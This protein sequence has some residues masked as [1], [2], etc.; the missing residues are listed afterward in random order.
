MP[1]A[2]TRL[3]DGYQLGRQTRDVSMQ[4][5]A[6]PPQIDDQ[7]RTLELTFS[8]ETAVSRWYGDE[9]L[10]HDAGCADLARLNDGAPLLFNHDRDCVIGVVEKAWIGEDKRGHAIVR[11]AK[12]EKA[13]EVVGMVNDLILRN[14]SFAY[15]ATDYVL[16]T[17]DPNRSSSDDVYTAMR[18]EALEI[19]IV[20]IPADTSIGINRSADPSAPAVRI[21]T[22]QPHINPAPAE[23]TEGTP[24]PVQQIRVMD[25]HHDETRSGGGGSAPMNPE[26]IRAAER[27]RI[28][29]I[30]ALG[31]KWK[32]PE[33]AQLHIEGG[34]TVQEARAAFLEALEKGA[35]QGPV[36]GA[37]VDL[38]HK[39]QRAYSFLKGMRAVANNDFK[40]AGLE[41]EVSDDIARQ[42]GR[43]PS[44]PNGL[45]LSADMPFAP[46][47]EHQRAVMHLDKRYRDAIQM[48]APYMTN[49]TATGGALVSTSL[50]AEEFIEVF[51]NM[52]VT[53]LLGVRTLVGL[54]GNVDI[55]RQVGASTASWVGE[56][57]A[58]SESEGT[59]DKVQ[60]RPK[61]LTA[62]SIL[63]RLMMQQSTPSIE[64]LARIDLLMQ[65]ALAL[66]QACIS[67]TG[68]NNQPLG[69]VNQPGVLSVIGGA[70]GKA[71]DFDDLIKLY[72]APRI[73]NAAIGSNAFALNSKCVGYLASLKATTGVSLWDPQ[74]G[75]VA[76][77]PDKLKGKPYAESNQLRGNLTKGTSV[78][79][80]SEIVY[81]NW[82]EAMIAQWG[83]FELGYN[84]YD[85]TL[86]KSGD[87]VVR[88][89]QT[90]DFG[91]RHGQS[92]AVMTDALTPGF[93]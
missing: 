51:R 58:G 90:V 67:G 25:Q 84:P 80:C 88:A 49:A 50:L 13:N 9:I 75:M 6:G 32:K 39:E 60:L 46:T 74:G 21:Q 61:M 76:G 28:A 69:I 2:S 4:G 23:P 16:E 83:V 3:T 85:T 63:S 48:R 86:F 1:D 73:A 59:F 62:Y 30:R 18:W 71:L 12:T 37:K 64:M 11:F 70:N 53:P 91:L 7:Q 41:K 72:T 14:V 55:P 40:E 8:S 5:A 36:A 87:I 45:F 19:S 35:Q 27:D 15:Q 82:Q 93:G 78:G 89:I 33:L 56:M 65:M 44:T 42:L 10:C 26:Q 57:S 24:M 81:G 52:L 17:A 43:D 79:I 20:T 29:S 54:I 66:D 68:S 77:S 38:S 47:P 22:R 34:S 92:F 31:D